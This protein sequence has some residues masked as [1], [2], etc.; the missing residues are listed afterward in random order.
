MHYRLPNGQ[1]VEERFD[2]E[3]RLNAVAW[4]D[5]PEHLAL[6]AAPRATPSPFQVHIDTRAQRIEFD[7]AGARFGV[8]F[9]PD[10]HALT[11]PSG[12][13][14]RE[15]RDDFGRVVLQTGPERGRRTARYDAADNTLE[16]H[17]AERVMQARYDAAG[18][19]VERSHRTHG[20]TEVRVV[21][22]VWAGAQ[23]VRIEDEEETRHF[24][25]DALGRLVTER[26]AFPAR[27]AL[28][29]REYVTRYHYD[30]FDRVVR[31]ELPEGSALGYRYDAIGTVSRIDY[32]TPPIAWWQRLLR[33]FWPTHGTRALL[34]DI[35]TDSRHGLIA[36][37]H[38]NG[39]VTRL[40]RD[41]EGRLTQR[42]DG[43]V[44]TRLTYDAAGRIA[45]LVRGEQHLALEHDALGRLLRVGGASEQGFTLDGNANRLRVE[46]AS[47]QTEY[48]YRPASDQLLARNGT[49][50]TYNAVGEPLR[51]EDTASAR[52]RTLAY[53]ALGQ[54]TSVAEDGRTLAHYRYNHA[55]QRVV[56]EVDGRSTRYLWQG[57][58]LVAETDET[59]RIRVRT[60]Y[61]GTRPF[62]Q[63]RYDER[64]QA[65]L[66][67]IHT[68]H[69]GAALA[70]TDSTGRTV[71][72]ADYD[73]FGRA[74]VRTHSLHSAAGPPARAASW[75]SSAHAA[76]TPAPAFDFSL[77]LPGQFEDPE[78]GWHYNLHRYYDP[79]T[80][81]YLTPDPIG[82]DGGPNLY[83]YA[84]ASPAMLADPAGLMEEHYDGP[85]HPLDLA[86]IGTRVHAMFSEYVTNEVQA[87]AENGQIYRANNTYDSV[88][89][90]KRPDAYDQRFKQVWE[91]KPISNR[92]DHDPTKYR[93]AER[94]VE[95]YL[96]TANR[97]SSGSGIF[98]GPAPA[99]C[100][101]WTRGDTRAL[102]S[103]G[104]ELG[105][106]Q[107]GMGRV[108]LVTL[109]H[110]IPHPEHG[111]DTGLVFYRADLIRDPVG[112]FFEA[113]LREL[114]KGPGWVLLPG[115]GPVPRPIP[116]AP[117]P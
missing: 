74:S 98:S 60:F 93:R 83:A 90:S 53:D 35:E 61:Q 68:D 109:Y 69:L 65:S 5:E 42:E 26:S 86:R 62:A 84:G 72:Q 95:R 41:H 55:R 113:L 7:L 13:E 112:E 56:R 32:Q 47:V 66:Y 17:D 23:R 18:R 100:G 15:H 27:V 85:A 16:V 91:L 48:A 30:E 29:A 1:R 43:P 101:G 87:G 44:S 10:G 104:Q 38:A 115:R 3:S 103:Q 116:P 45:M 97:T 82:L 114:A 4:L 11:L 96:D 111:T 25:Y 2:T 75:I 77:R 105:Y 58:R 70:V 99:Q 94:Q 9:E 110:D 78:T 50:Y 21:R 22:H 63:V 107:G 92:A 71:W 52:V 31:T 49:R 33:R 108:Y 6:P 76:S 28:P 39:R 12:A 73:V 8:R 46:R 106:V 14:H 117:R 81:R 80:G 24:D 19:L 20:Q 64:G 57:E 88:F 79:D 102:F 67:A 54:V 51:I 89:G 36:H 59:G 34:A 37:T 40:A